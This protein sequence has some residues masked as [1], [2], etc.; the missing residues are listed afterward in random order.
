MPVTRSARKRTARES[1]APYAKKR[2]A[3]SARKRKEEKKAP[4]SP[5]LAEASPP[6]QPSA[7]PMLEEEG[8][9]E[10]EEATLAQPAVSPMAEEEEKEEEERA[11]RTGAEQDEYTEAR[12]EE[13]REQQHQQSTA[14]VASAPP[15]PAEGGYGLLGSFVWNT[16]PAIFKSFI[17]PSQPAAEQNVSPQK[18]LPPKSTATVLPPEVIWTVRRHD[19]A[20]STMLRCRADPSDEDDVWLANEACVDDGEVVTALGQEGDFMLVRTKEGDEGFIK[21]AYV[22][23]STNNPP[24]QLTEREVARQ[25]KGTGQRERQTERE[26]LSELTDR[27]TLAGAAWRPAPAPAP[28][29]SY[30]GALSDDTA[31]AETGAA[32]P[33]RT[34][35][36]P[37]EQTVEP[38]RDTEGEPPSTARRS[39]RSK[40]PPPQKYE[41]G[42][43]PASEWTEPKQE[44][45]TRNVQKRETE[46]TSP[47]QL[48]VEEKSTTKSPVQLTG[49]GAPAPAWTQQEE[50]GADVG[51][52]AAEEEEV[53]EEHSS[54]TEMNAEEMSQPDPEHQ[55]GTVGTMSVKQ[56]KDNLKQL[57]LNT[58]GKKA[59]LQERL[60]EHLLQNAE[61]YETNREREAMPDDAGEDAAESDVAEMDGEPAA[62]ADDSA[63]GD[64][65]ESSFVSAG[66]V[67]ET[68]T[69]KDSPVEM[70]QDEPAAEQESAAAT[71][72][73]AGLSQPDAVVPPNRPEAAFSKP[74]EEDRLPIGG[75]IPARPA[76]GNAAAPA[77]S[78]DA[79]GASM[80]PAL[81]KDHGNAL[82]APKSL[83]RAVETAR[84]A[85]AVLQS[86][87]AASA[88]PPVVPPL[89]PTPI[90]RSLYY[91]HPVHNYIRDICMR[92]RTRQSVAGSQKRL[93]TTSVLSS[94]KRHR[95]AAD[96]VSLP[97]WRPSFA[98]A[99][100]KSEDALPKEPP[101]SAVESAGPAVSNRMP[102]VDATVADETVPAQSE[103][104]ST[105]SV[106]AKPA[107][108]SAAAQ[109]FSIGLPG[110][111]APASSTKANSLA[112]GNGHR[113]LKRSAPYSDR[114]AT[115]S[116]AMVPVAHETSRKIFETLDRMTSPPATKKSKSL[117]P[118]STT[119]SSGLSSRLRAG[120][121]RR[122]NRDL[123]RSARP[124]TRAAD[125]GLTPAPASR[126]GQ[127]DDDGPPVFSLSS[128][129]KTKEPRRSPTQSPSP[130]KTA[131]G[132]ITTP[133]P[134]GSMF[135]SHETKQNVAAK[136]VMGKPICAS[137]PVQTRN[138]GGQKWSTSPTKS[139]DNF[140]VPKSVGSSSRTSRSSG[141]SK[142][143]EVASSTFTFSEPNTTPRGSAKP[144]SQRL[145]AAS[146]DL[147]TFEFAAASTEKS[148]SAKEASSL[149]ATTHKS[150][151]TISLSSP[152]DDDDSVA[153]T[154]ES[155]RPGTQS[156]FTFGA[157][158]PIGASSTSELKKPA[159]NAADTKKPEA[160]AFSFGSG[161]PIKPKAG[162]ESSSTASD[163]NKPGVKF[164]APE[165][166]KVAELSPEKTESKPAIS[167]GAA[168]AFSFGAPK[169]S[170]TAA[171]QATATA[172][173]GFSFGS[174]NSTATATAA[175]A[176][177]KP[178]TSAPSTGAAFSFGASKPASS[179]PPAATTATPAAETKAAAPAFAFGAEKRSADDSA[180]A[181]NKPASGA[182]FQFGGAAKPSFGASS[183][184]ESAS[185]GS[186]APF[187]FGGGGG[188]TD[189]AAKPSFGATTGSA[190]PFKFGGGGGS[191]DAAAK[192]SFGASPAFGAS[193]A[194]GSAT[195]S[196]APFKFGGGA[197]STDAAASSGAAATFQFGA[198]PAKPA[199][200]S[201]AAFQFGAGAASSTATAAPAFAFGATKP[202]SASSGSAA[203][204][205]AAPAFAFGQ[206]AAPAAASQPAFAFGAPQGG[207]SGGFG[208]QATGGFGAPASGFG[209]NTAAAFGATAPSGFGAG[210]GGGFGG[211]APATQGFG[212]TAPAA[213]GGFGSSSGFGAS[214]FGASAPSGGFGAP[215]SNVGF[216]GAASP[217][218]G[219]QP[220]FG[221]PQPAAVGGFGAASPAFGAEPAT[222]FGQAPSAG[223]FGQAATPAFGAPNPAFNAGAGAGAG[224]GPPSGGFNMGGAPAQQGRKPSR[225][226]RRPSRK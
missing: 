74:E 136:H 76:A 135:A 176:T 58:I 206:P 190:A 131:A 100:A 72:P 59:E 39:R 56:L 101:P 215:A 113:P 163:A 12:G 130:G 209:A 9:E 175:G 188:S 173:T 166:S 214:G 11:E 91:D 225:K 140:S 123:P 24:A 102:V 71:M 221:Q 162:A 224:A 146:A 21:I 117:A 90:R 38:Q 201:S 82:A 159:D 46:T 148:A 42:H 14:M 60:R 31:V 98:K 143:A 120:G 3:P 109:W 96:A 207:G 94:A 55:G 213:S 145:K 40:A 32:P 115:T 35:M 125:T 222:P 15:A 111:A 147:P 197:G 208:A 89:R 93:G 30:A 191:T 4:E 20:G 27:Q 142:S 10:K 19:A 36:Q 116:T 54:A 118:S 212:A 45:A 220:A 167:V 92:G 61:L 223:G 23:K 170:G 134:P 63:A 184:S 210:A 156:T 114:S 127:R 43:G 203:S 192:P 126:T 5:V 99:E 28:A 132:L 66:S 50:T 199:A 160:P 69:G 144:L 44:P 107:P 16:V 193:S 205:A 97:S 75:A 110:S 70:Q 216:G 62:A 103:G 105:S 217:A 106:R 22:H 29:M 48:T 139:D 185:A 187:K 65:A 68:S 177:E 154:V 138:A 161:M 26:P 81:S 13:A 153:K 64:E 51:S 108:G 79:N 104:F 186:A 121:M 25:K 47:V 88:L 189:A 180:S 1:S 149:G 34:P 78:E 6:P 150:K 87:A 49:E 155:P 85:D 112:D 53:R 194:G 172:G 37:A 86:P 168:P 77:S 95:P 181:S 8:Q 169:A 129:G 122:G 178:A 83:P 67:D 219:A 211:G 183:A 2:P 196:A 179:P 164:G 171:P 80:V 73:P 182:A 204:G 18:S 218:F 119:K 174:T 33:A 152:A 165:T 226:F 124:A 57:G 151:P 17:A 41:P 52:R 198:A 202:P 128:V 137:K 195:G 84:T 141:E 200:A 157:A 133:I 158:K 7:V